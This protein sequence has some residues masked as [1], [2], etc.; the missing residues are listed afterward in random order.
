MLP[1]VARSRMS[2]PMGS[3]NFCEDGGLLVNSHRIIPTDPTEFHAGVYPRALGCNRLRCPECGEWVRNVAGL[4]VS[5]AELRAP[6]AEAAA[7][8]YALADLASVPQAAPHTKSRLYVCRCRWR[9]EL[10]LTSLESERESDEDPPPWV[11]AGHPQP[12]LP[13]DIDGVVIREDSRVEPLV[14]D[15][16]H[17]IIPRQGSCVG[18]PWYWPARAFVRLLHSANG[19]ELAEAVSRAVAKGMADDDVK[20]RWDVLEFFVQL[21]IA[22]G[23]E[24]IV[25]IAAGDRRRVAGVRNPHRETRDVLKTLE[26]KLFL[27]VHRRAV[28]GDPRCIEIERVEVLNAGRGAAWSLRSLAE[29]DHD[30]LVDNAERIVIAHLALAKP[31]LGA[32]L[33]VASPHAAKIGA[34]LA[35]LRGVGRRAVRKRLRG[36]VETTRERACLDEAVQQVLGAGAKQSDSRLIFSPGTDFPKLIR[37][38]LAG[39][40]A[41]PTDPSDLSPLRKVER[42]YRS[43]FGTGD[44]EPFARGVLACVTDPDPAIRARALSFF[45]TFPDAAGARDMLSLAR[46]RPE[47]FVGIRNDWTAGPDLEWQLLRSI[48]GLILRRDPPALAFGR[49]VAV[50]R[51]RADALIAA[52]THVDP[53]WVK[54]NAEKIVSAS[55]AAGVAILFNLDA[56]E[57]VR[58]IGIRIAPFASRD[59]DFETDL[60]R[61]VADPS[62]REEIRSAAHRAKSW[63]EGLRR[64]RRASIRR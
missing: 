54:K 29:L 55:P 43:A 12:T 39:G 40:G 62:T 50:K 52:L 13:L 7:K 21:P 63:A 36:F 3:Q 58:A 42:V 17:G 47:L 51:A 25:A 11:C 41:F 38:N 10:E 33:D 37:E 27:F 5:G 4:I 19:A 24:E 48:S 16:L 57:D 53:A 2:R 46:A 64:R 1:A 14:A 22:P 8:I 34:Q 18:T 28:A 45:E 30:W 15:A 61:F 60:D 31:L 56:P 32:L 59:P 49:A 35:K 26:E 23:A 9:N 44:A 20:V 6:E